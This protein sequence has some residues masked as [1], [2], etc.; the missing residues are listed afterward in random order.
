MRVRIGLENEIEG[1]SLAWALDH[2]GCFAYGKDGPEAVVMMGKAIPE[3]I[4]WLAEHTSSSWFNPEEIDI[5]LV[6]TWDVYAID[7]SYDRV[8][9][10][11]EINAWFITDWLPLTAEEIEHGQQILDWTRMDL[12][13]LSGRLR[14]SVL[15]RLYDGERWSIR[16]ILK[17]IGAAEW[18]YMKQLGLS[19]RNETDLASD[20][21]IRLEEVRTELKQVLNEL[22]GANRVIGT[23]GEFWSP[24]K[25]LRRA[26][27]HERDHIQH[28]QRLLVQYPS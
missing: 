9:E 23:E 20:A 25:I 1:R 17:H 3:Y 13:N 19:K 12:L 10:G 11:Y 27:W 15:D 6:D 22:D 4:D 8:K 14:E 2:P 18:W 5:R 28:I 16:G 24:R 21:F 7:E 26:A